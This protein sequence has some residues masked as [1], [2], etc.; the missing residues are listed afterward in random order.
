[1]VLDQLLVLEHDLLSED[2]RCLDLFETSSAHLA[3]GEDRLQVRWAALALSTASSI[4]AWVDWGT[5]VTTWR[6][7]SWSSPKSPNLVGCRVVHF[8]PLVC[9]AL[10]PLPSNHI[11]GCRRHLGSNPTMTAGA[12]SLDKAPCPLHSWESGLPQWQS[13]PRRWAA[14][15]PRPWLGAW[16]RSTVW[17]ALRGKVLRGQIHFSPRRLEESGEYLDL[18]A[19]AGIETQLELRFYSCWCTHAFP[20]SLQEYI[21]VVNHFV[22]SIVHVI[23]LPQTPFEKVQ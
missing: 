7:L 9:R 2:E 12:N 10:Q 6:Q 3:M 1:M 5:L 22:L 11:L 14:S 17:R 15:W 16:L 23:Q 18:E 13:W 8:D 19:S 20:P 21:A 4:S